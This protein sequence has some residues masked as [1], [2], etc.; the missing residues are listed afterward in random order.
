LPLVVRSLTFAYGDIFQAWT[1]DTTLQNVLHTIFKSPFNNFLPDL[2]DRTNTFADISVLDSI[3]ARM[4]VDSIL[5]PFQSD[6]NH[7]FRR[8]LSDNVMFTT[9]LPNAARNFSQRCRY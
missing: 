7:F 8:I 5:I 3:T 4:L 2:L 9:G 6:P 1:T